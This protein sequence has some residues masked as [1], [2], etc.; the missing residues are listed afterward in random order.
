MQKNKFLIILNKIKDFLSRKKASPVEKS[1]ELMKNFSRNGVKDC[2]TGDDTLSIKGKQMLLKEEINKEAR[3]VIK[4]AMTNPEILAKFIRSK[5]TLITKSRYMDKILALMGEEEGFVTPMS[6]SRAL[7]FTLMTNIFCDVKLE[8]GC[9]TPELFAF[10]EEPVDIY[11]FSHQFHLW[12]SYQNRLP[13]FE[14][15]NMRNFKNFWQSQSTAYFSVE[16][17]ISLKDIIARETEAVDF[18]TEIARE[19]VGQKN[20]LQKLLEGNAV[21]L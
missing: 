6:G 9:K 16:E 17:I 13:G 7:F 21:D 4:E 3:S 1:V 14:E 8:I 2:F 5:G 19:F 11:T 12:L 15:K 18:V 10:R 20:S